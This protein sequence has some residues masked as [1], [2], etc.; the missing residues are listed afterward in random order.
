MKLILTEQQYKLLLKEA[1]I[2]S[3]TDVLGKYKNAFIEK[4]GENAAGELQELIAD[5]FGNEENYKEED[6]TLFLISKSEGKL[7]PF[8]KIKEY[9]QFI[10][11]GTYSADRVINGFPRALQGDIIVRQ[12]IAEIL[13]EIPEEESSQD[14]YPLD[15]FGEKVKELIDNSNNWIQMIYPEDGDISGWKF[16]IYTNTT[17]EV[18]YA[19]QQVYPIAKAFNAGLKLASKGNL[20]RMQNSQ[21]QGKGVS[22]YISY[23]TIKNN[24]HFELYNQIKSAV[25]EL[26]TNGSVSGDKNL[27][28]NITYRYEFDIALPTILNG[29]YSKGATNTQYYAHYMSNSGN[30]NPAPDNPD[31]FGAD[32][33]Y[34]NQAYQSQLNK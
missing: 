19:A 13:V 16:H 11:N 26:N 4:F 5:I 15:S 23:D 2:P 18:A 9:L 27:S 10:A 20:Q 29:N 25:S 24:K 6:G 1:Q 34:Y 7:I 22:I 8:E 12:R 3:V 21:Q 28:K 30:Y 17:D 14:G 33:D 32:R 31:I